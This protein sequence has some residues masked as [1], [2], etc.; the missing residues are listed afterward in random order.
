MVTELED[1]L[2][3]NGYKRIPSDPGPLVEKPALS[4][5]QK[6]FSSSK[7]H[8]RGLLEHWD[9]NEQ[10]PLLYRSQDF[11]RSRLVHKGQIKISIW[12]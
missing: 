11:S 10:S 8:D 3:N 7:G 2:Q 5:K 6:L 1:R 4:W 9:S 12:K